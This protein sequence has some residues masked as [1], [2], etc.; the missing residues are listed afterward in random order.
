MAQDYEYDDD[1]LSDSSTVLQAA[2]YGRPHPRPL[3]KVEYRGPRGSLRPPV[4]HKGSVACPAH[5]RAPLE[6]ESSRPAFPPSEQLE[7]T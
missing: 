4:G 5:Q 6:K 2:V 3:P 7:T 1:G